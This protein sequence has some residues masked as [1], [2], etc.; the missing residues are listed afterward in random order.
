MGSAFESMGSSV[1]VLETPGNCV[2]SQ[3]HHFFSSL[4]LFD[5]KTVLPS[6]WN[7]SNK[8]Q[9]WAKLSVTMSI[10][11]DVFPGKEEILSGNS[12][13]WRVKLAVGF[14]LKFFWLL[15]VTLAGLVRIPKVRYLCRDLPFLNLLLMVWH[16]YS[17]FTTSLLLWGN[18]ESTFSIS[19]TFSIKLSMLSL[20]LKTS[21][22]R[23]LLTIF[24]KSFTG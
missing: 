20:F 4:L 19:N 8:K 14:S 22:F 6:M 11:L 15:C 21:C 7:C 5:H 10:W 16:I 9:L 12:S 3:K 2:Q 13:S 24:G 1:F 17:I 18:S 23:N